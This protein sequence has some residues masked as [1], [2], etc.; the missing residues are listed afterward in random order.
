[1]V[2]LENLLSSMNNESEYSES[3]LNVPSTNNLIKYGHEYWNSKM[4]PGIARACL[5]QPGPAGTY[6]S[7]MISSIIVRVI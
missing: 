7:Y 6:E 1:M 3:C 5:G 4:Y 2:Y